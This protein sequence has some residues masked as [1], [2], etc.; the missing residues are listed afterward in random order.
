M[1]GYERYRKSDSEDGPVETIITGREVQ[2]PS[3]PKIEGH[4]F[5]G[6]V[7]EDPSL[8]RREGRIRRKT[9]A[10]IRVDH[11]LSDSQMRALD[12][13]IQSL[14]NTRRTELIEN[15]HGINI[16]TPSN[17]W[18]QMSGGEKQQFVKD[19]LL[20]N[21]GTA[22]GKPTPGSPSRR[23]SRLTPN[24]VGQDARQK[25]IMYL[26][27]T[28]LLDGEPRL[29]RQ[30]DDIFVGKKEG[31]QEE[32]EGFWN[33]VE[34]M[35]GLNEYPLKHAGQSIYDYIYDRVITPGWNSIYN[36]AMSGLLDAG[37]DF[38]DPDEKEI[39]T[40]KGEGGTGK[41][42]PEWDLSSPNMVRRSKVRSKVPHELGG[43]DIEGFLLDR[44]IHN[45]ADF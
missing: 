9:I 18:D 12:R 32:T 6:Y 8:G 37:L 22:T 40:F 1:S 28:A 7:P 29:H 14:K 38:R 26:R 30:G 17:E 11:I 16:P 44:N 19:W 24:Q 31:F 2:G 23:K 33:Y 36:S 25:A 4:T 21:V 35:V 20:T 34:S 39:T 42:R 10:G 45:V 13:E 5:Q 43:K 3:L 41:R 15:E 27:E